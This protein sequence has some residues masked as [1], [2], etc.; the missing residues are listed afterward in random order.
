[1]NQ[2]IY[3][4]VILGSNPVVVNMMITEGLYNY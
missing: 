3:S 1:M 2:E 4:P